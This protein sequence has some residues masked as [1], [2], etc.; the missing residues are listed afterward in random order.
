VTSLGPPGT[1]SLDPIPLAF[2]LP[3]FLRESWVSPAA[4]SAYRDRLRELSTALLAEVVADLEP[5]RVL[6]RRIAGF[7]IFALQA[8]ARE[9]GLGCRYRV[10]Q[11]AADSDPARPGLLHYDVWVGPEPLLEELK[12]N[13][14][15]ASGELLMVPACCLHAARERAELV[16]QLDEIWLT[17]AATA[18]AHREGAQIT[19][20]GSP[21]DNPLLVRLGLRVAGHA[22]CSFDC[23]AT[24]RGNARVLAR[25][26]SGPRAA[27]FAQLQ[28]VLS[29]PAA[30]SALHGIAELRLP[31]ARFL[32]HT[33][34]TA[35]EYQV[36]WE[37]QT[38]PALG[39]KGL[40]FPYRR[41]ARAP[42]AP[43]RLRLLLD[44]PTELVPLSIRRP[45][46]QAPARYLEPDF[47][48]ARLARPQPDG[49]DTRMALRLAPRAATS[50]HAWPHLAEGHVAVRES[51]PEVLRRWGFRQAELDT[52]QLEAAVE[53]LRAWPEAYAQF[54]QL[55]DVLHPVRD[56][57]VAHSEGSSS[58]HQSNQRGHIWATVFD[59]LG[60]A[61]AFV[62]E[63][64]HTKL[65]DLG[66]ALESDHHLVINPR[67]Q[68]F[69]SPIRKD[70]PRPMSAVFHAQYS[71][72]YV[73]ALDLQLLKL[74]SSG[75]LRERVLRLLARN[76]ARM[77]QGFELLQRALRVDAR[78]EPFVS[79]FMRWSAEV[80]EQ[81]R[82]A[83]ADGP[84]VNDARIP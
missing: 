51:P 47:D 26:G 48:W 75:E 11:N 68:L 82:R 30:F 49:Y 35:N 54:C 59:P 57:D 28:E 18:S 38:Y 24:Q 29:W 78:G 67:T 73:T 31:V 76:V 2:G 72:I 16:A 20:R 4:A 43:A 42:G 23:E 40:R 27:Q 39:A 19:L 71:F 64:A 15:A 12:R 63:L 1:A 53:Y 58:H 7:Q 33:A 46:L 55:I 83:L 21:H 32:T 13:G 74:N 37:G 34:A 9:R 22:P 62:H 60:L 77:E 45:S 81:G 10:V 80:L 14:G 36:R 25:A 56:A 70:R 84:D 41:A 52:P 50:G 3:P 66:L 8:M 79:A 44:A 61:Q 5:G 6:R 17:A 69:E 65:F